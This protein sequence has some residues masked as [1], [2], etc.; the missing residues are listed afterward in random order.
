MAYIKSPLNYSGGKY[1]LLN[2]IIPLFP[3]KINTFVD[4][5][6]GSGTISANVN[7][8][9][10]IYNEISEPVFNIIE[11]MLKTDENIILSRFDWLVKEY[12]LNLTNKEGYLKLREDYNNTRDIS[13]LCMLNYY[14]YGN[15]LRFNS[16]GNYNMPFGNGKQRYSPRS[17]KHIHAF[18]DFFKNKKLILSNKDFRDF[19]YNQLKQGDLVY[20]DPPYI[21]S[22]M[23]YNDMF[24]WDIGVEYQLYDILD[25][26]TDRGIM[27]ALSN[28]FENRGEVHNELI[29]WSKKHNVHYLNHNYGNAFETTRKDKGLANK[30]VEV[31]ITN[32]E[33]G[34][35]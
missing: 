9:T 7:A 6:G 35:N 32:Y 3:T 15:T 29:E 28:V 16:K 14:G 31:L 8:N 22:P 19:D 25:S 21:T 30:T 11:W 17:I 4:L 1:K 27:F 18:K 2:Q 20:F 33:L 10:I 23:P 26:L 5:F 24:K 12:N 34:G 13:M